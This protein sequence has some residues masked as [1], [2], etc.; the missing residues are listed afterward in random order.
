MI[1]GLLRILYCKIN[2]NKI[3]VIILTFIRRVIYLIFHPLEAVSRHR[4]PQLQVDE[5][6]TY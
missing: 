1:I 4:D 6:Y 2:H 3:L 5:K